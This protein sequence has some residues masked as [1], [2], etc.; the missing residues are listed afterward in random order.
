MYKILKKIK[1]LKLRIKMEIYTCEKCNKEF[2]YKYNYKRHINRK[3][4][5]VKNTDDNSFKCEYCNNTFTTKGNLT[6]HIKNRCIVK[7]SQE[8]I[9]KLNEEN[10]LLKNKIS[11]IEITNNTNTTNSNNNNININNTNNNTNNITNNINIVN[12]GRE[13]LE[14]LSQEEIDQILNAGAGALTQHVKMIHLNDRLPEYQ[15][16]YLS[17]LRGNTCLIYF[18]K[19]WMAT[20][21]ND[22][23]DDL[24]TYGT[25]DIRDLLNKNENH[26]KKYIRTQ[27]KKL[28]DNIDDH[29]KKTILDQ[30]K[31]IKLALYNDKNK[32]NYKNK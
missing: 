23:I 14:K 13:R 8:L 12:F 2:N 11:K 22:K 3:Y 20:D 10:K 30:K 16:I 21:I 28:I 15:N 25:E 27:T 26:E 18:N 1:R 32:I 7:E 17:N 6:R 19:Q 4:S 24:I 29:D 31:K 9:N 5:C